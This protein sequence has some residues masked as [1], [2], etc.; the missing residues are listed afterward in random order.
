MSKITYVIFLA[1]AS[2]NEV[3]QIF[4]LGNIH[5]L[6]L[7]YIIMFMYMLLK[8][9]LNALPPWVWR[10]GFGIVGLSAILYLILL[11]IGAPSHQIKIIDSSICLFVWIKSMNYLN[12][13]KE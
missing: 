12:N 3:G 6:D 8:M 9:I 1:V 13:Y 5:I 11:S 4:S 7:L 10:D 2:A